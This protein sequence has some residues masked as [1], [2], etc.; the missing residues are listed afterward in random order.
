MTDTTETPALIGYHGDAELKRLT[1]EQLDEHRQLDQI[2]QGTYW[3]SEDGEE[4]AKGSAVGCLTHDPS[5]GHDK[6]PARWGIPVQ[7]AYLMD[8]I[9]E[10]LPTDKVGS[11][12]GIPVYRGGSLASGTPAARKAFRSSFRLRPS[13]RVALKPS[14]KRTTAV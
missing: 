8:A 7:M 4:L 5:G 3:R 12:L 1:L 6:F 10:A 14:S 9:F 13:T 11:G 2:V